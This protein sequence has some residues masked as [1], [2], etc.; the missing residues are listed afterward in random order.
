MVQE[1]ALELSAVIS[2]LAGQTRTVQR[3]VAGMIRGFLDASEEL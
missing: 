2:L 1:F 3:Q